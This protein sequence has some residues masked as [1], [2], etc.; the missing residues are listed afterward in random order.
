MATSPLLSNVHHR[1]MIAP[2]SPLSTRLS[3][4]GAQSAA[5]D[6]G[7]KCRPLVRA[8]MLYL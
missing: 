5:P 7:R 6:L 3:G 2:V 1:A 8:L 4:V